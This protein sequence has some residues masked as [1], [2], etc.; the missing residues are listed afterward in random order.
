MEKEGAKR[1]EL[2][3]VDDKRKITAVIGGSLTGDFLPIQLIY[4]GTTKR[5]LPTVEFPRNWH[6][7]F[8]HDHWANE[9]AMIA[10]DPDPLRQ[11]YII[12]REGEYPSPV[13]PSV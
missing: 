8:Y 3:A 5:C 2:T 10:K 9:E 1:V 6:A 11:E 4:Q 7:T 13:Y 12:K